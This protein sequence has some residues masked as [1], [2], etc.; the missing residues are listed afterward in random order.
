[1]AATVFSARW[2]HPHLQLGGD[3]A[4]HGEV[5]RHRRCS[6]E[7]TRSV[8]RRLR[9][10]HVRWRF[11]RPRPR[12]QAG[13]RLRC[14]ARVVPRRGD[15][16]NCHRLV[17]ASSRC[18]RDP[19]FD[20]ARL[21]SAGDPRWRLPVPTVRPRCRPA[22]M[23]PARGPDESSGLA[24]ASRMQRRDG[25][26]AVGF[27]VFEGRDPHPRCRAAPRARPY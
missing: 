25:L 21:R 14:G 8:R 6:F 3:D 13:N 4:R 24:P 2:S 12:F 15:A 11:L 23:T 17:A 20:L 27:R 9:H 26:V 10:A 5:R 18:L 1:M 16:G 19:A 7:A 22:L